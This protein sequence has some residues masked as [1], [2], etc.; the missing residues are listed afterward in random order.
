MIV[1]TSMFGGMAKPLQEPVF[2]S[3]EVKMVCFTD[4]GDQ[5]SDHWEIV[6][7]TTDLPPVMASRRCKL[8]P[9]LMVDD[10]WTLYLDSNFRLLVDPRTLLHH[11]EFVTH[12]HR[13]RTRI[14][15]EVKEIVRLDKADPGIV[16]AQ[17]AAY[18]AAGFDTPQNPQ[19]HL[20]ETGVLL[21][22]DTAA[23]RELNEAWWDELCRHSH[24]DQLS[25]D[26][27]A[28][29]QQFPLS[30]WPGTV[31]SSPYFEHVRKRRAK[32]KITPS[33]NKARSNRQPFWYMR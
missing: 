16:R 3:P 1:Y 14:S 7:L 25:L 15:D 11:G 26:Y 20:A 28:W 33:P 21:R 30:Y 17:V 31:D 8:L 22:R 2:T 6:R 4:H 12:H 32:P 19:Q 13:W 29:Q 23:V 10:E 9:H 27:V 18:H 24:R 5:T